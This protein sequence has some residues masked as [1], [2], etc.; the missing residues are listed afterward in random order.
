MQRAPNW[1]RPYHMVAAH[2]RELGDLALSEDTLERGIG[3]FPDS[4]VLVSEAA[5][6]A[7][8]K[9]QWDEAV[10]LW[11]KIVDRAD[12]SPVWLQCYA[13][14]LMVLGRFDRADALLQSY[15]QRFPDHSGFL[16]VQGMIAAT[17]GEHD[18]ALTLWSKYRSLH[19]NDPAGWDHYGRALQAREL[20][21][22]EHG[23]GKGR[24]EPAVPVR[25]EV[26]S[27]E[28]ARELMLGLESLGTNCEFGLLQRRFGAEP[29]G[30]LRFNATE[31][32][33]LVSAL[34][35]RFEGMGDPENTQLTTLGN[36]EYFLED[37]RWGLGMHTF[38]FEGQTN[39]SEL[40]EKLCKRVGFLKRKM[41][42]DLEEARKV[43]V[44]LDSK[45]S[46]EEVQRTPC[47]A[48]DDR[49]RGVVAYPRRYGRFRRFSCRGTRQGA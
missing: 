28:P 8:R 47:R 42:E 40:Y 3:L 7:E 37:R 48:A 24:N 13:H 26:V 45:L 10:S 4:D 31:S 46:L 38:L 14:D 19:P 6:V 17:R 25:I 2:A 22:L 1:A 11:E 41:L 23:T 9:G 18:L 33:S 5:S 43:F 32:T 36:G 15:R 12:A 30:L 27:D 35:Q 16:A 34:L 21:R 29:P 39:P 44:F 20:E 49:R